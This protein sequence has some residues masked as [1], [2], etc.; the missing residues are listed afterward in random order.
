M[1]ARVRVSKRVMLGRETIC[2][3][4]LPMLLALCPKRL[5]EDTSTKGNR[6]LKAEA[7]EGQTP[8]PQPQSLIPSGLSPGRGLD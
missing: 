3:E 5:Y 2:L 1:L 6:K 8:F 7:G 4:L